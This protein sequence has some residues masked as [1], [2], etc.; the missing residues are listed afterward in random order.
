MGMVFGKNK[1]YF[2][3]LRVRR[4]YLHGWNPRVWLVDMVS[5]L[6]QGFLA[7]VVLRD[8]YTVHHWDPHVVL[9]GSKGLPAEVAN[10]L[11]HTSRVVKT[12]ASVSC[13]SPLNHFQLKKIFL[14]VCGL[15]TVAAYS[16]YGLTR[17]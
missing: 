16:R 3:G 4:V 17:D 7:G 9:T 5:H 12:V 10:H 2:D 13:S 14:A 11:T 8:N 15:K 1:I 6:C